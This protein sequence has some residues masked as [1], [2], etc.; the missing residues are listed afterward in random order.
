MPGAP[1][2]KGDTGLPG[3]P[4]AP[5]KPGEM[6]MRGPQGRDGNPGPA[7]Q[8]GPPGPRGY[9][10]ND[11]KPGPMGPAGPPG[12]PGPPGETLGYDVA[13]LTALLNQGQTKGVDVLGDQ[14]MLDQLG[15]G[16]TDEEKHALVLKAYEHVKASFIRLTRPNGQQ[17]AP[18]KTCRDLFAAYP[19]Y[20][21]GEYWIDPNEGDPQDAILVYCE[22]ERRATC[23]R[24][25]P[26]QTK[27][28]SYKGKEEEEAW[29]S[30][31]PS[32]MK[33]H[34]KTDSYQMG[35][36]QLMSAK[37]SQ[38]ITFHCKNTVAY[39]DEKKDTLRNGLKLL[40]WNDAE[41]TPDGPQRLR[42]EAD[43]DG[44][45]KRSNNWDKSVLTYTTDKSQRL[46]IVDIAV[47]DIGNANQEFRI[48][49]GAACFY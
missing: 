36:L 31:L 30:E 39:K 16:L 15:E 20:N 12:P 29:L 37:A 14:P 48:E 27:V 1:G 28:I 9:N 49:L 26:K 42:Y 23:I 17:S 34:Y 45:R 44:C 33:I 13:A 24:P 46:P 11:G 25:Q 32:G 22:K 38:Q 47:R 40:S 2:L 7:G 10:G 18:A 5:G 3:V 4:G 41:L 43:E 21:S 19:E 6:G 8:A 35:F